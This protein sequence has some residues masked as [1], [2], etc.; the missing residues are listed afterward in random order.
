[1][2]RTAVLLFL[3]LAAQAAAK[4]PL[5][6][7]D[8]NLALVPATSRAFDLPA[9]RTSGPDLNLSRLPAGLGADLYL[10]LLRPLPADVMMQRLRALSVD[11][12]M[13]EVALAERAHALGRRLAGPDFELDAAAPLTGADYALPGRPLAVEDWQSWTAPGLKV[14][15]D[16]PRLRLSPPSMLMER[17]AKHRFDLEL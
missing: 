5:D 16:L 17:V 6:P 11:L 9:R 12:H 14:D 15:F 7:E 3:I 13:E 2:L 10:D 8:L 1:M 4:V